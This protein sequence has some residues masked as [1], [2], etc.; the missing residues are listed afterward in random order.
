MPPKKIKPEIE[1]IEYMNIPLKKGFRYATEDEAINA[2]KVLLWGKY[3]IP[4]KKLYDNKA[5][6]KAP[7]RLTRAKELRP[8]FVLAGVQIKERGA[9]GSNKQAKA[10]KKYDPEYDYQIEDIPALEKIYDDID[11]KMDAGDDSDELADMQEAVY[12]NLQRLEGL[13][14][15]TGKNII[16]PMTNTEQPKVPRAVGGKFEKEHGLGNIVQAYFYV[17]FGEKP[18][19]KG[20]TKYRPATAEEAINNKMVSLYGMKKIP[21]DLD[22]HGQM[23]GH[24]GNI[25][26]MNK[27][28]LQTLYAGMKGK[29]NRIS[30]D[31]EILVF[32]A[33]N[34]GDSEPYE[35]EME[36]LNDKDYEVAKM[37]LKIINAMN[38]LEGKP[39]ITKMDRKP[40][41]YEK[42]ETVYK[43]VVLPEGRTSP[44]RREPV[45]EETVK[46]TKSKSKVPHKEEE[47]NNIEIV[48]N[49]PKVKGYHIFSNDEQ[50]INI[51]HSYFDKENRLKT[52]KA[53]K[54][55]L[56]NVIL[57]PHHYQEKDISKF[58]FEK[59]IAHPLDGSKPIRRMHGK[60]LAGGKIHVDKMFKKVGET[61]SNAG[62]KIESGVT[63]LGKTL[64][65]GAK[66]IG[67]YATDVV[68]GVGD[69]PP[70]VRDIINKY[71]NMTISDVMVGRAPVPTAITTAL[72]VVSGG[73]FQEG[74][75]TQPYDKL[76]HLFMYVTMSDGSKILF[77]KNAQINSAVNSPLPDK[78]ETLPIPIPNKTTT[79][80]TFLENG[81][82]QMGDKFFPYDPH[83]NNCQ[84]FI[85]GLLTGNGWINQEQRNWIKQDTGQLF[86]NN[87]YLGTVARGVT[88]IGGI[89][90]RLINGFGIDTKM[91]KK[92]GHIQSILFK[93][94]EWK[95]QEAENWIK[96]H[97]FKCDIDIKPNHFRF[98]QIE[99]NE[100]KYN[101]RTQRAGGEI[102]FIIGYKI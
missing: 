6:L 86:A 78:T 102:E 30:K 83:Y 52:D 37:Q 71:S 54:L 57:H 70:A 65:K 19:D 12:D 80:N 4:R 1:K 11:A 26:E 17:Y 79:L 23:I 50:T 25:K 9:K 92:S 63:S 93:R 45:K 67:Q 84:D 34:T 53:S 100:N 22:K 61:F 72:N 90:E 88:N 97:K 82:K 85:I 5:K 27:A 77:E 43:D 68:Y 69:Y 91:N 40:L 2:N 81:K 8:D 51:P 16:V 42:H 64:E 101:Y 60:G 33:N 76:F 24:A 13:K 15:M 75:N 62:H 74:M 39:K 49:T 35:K 95:Q 73:T 66:Q 41:I 58:F 89:G 47:H 32:K 94:P 96:E 20:R 99:P 10:L 7:N 38:K 98:R 3:T 87:K 59:G 29:R 28:Q 21:E 18:P 55:R 48:Q 31:F 44:P 36:E 46:V 56:K 14:K